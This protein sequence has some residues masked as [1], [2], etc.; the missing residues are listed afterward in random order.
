MH[1]LR[2]KVCLFFGFLFKFMVHELRFRVDGLR[3]YV[4]IFM[5]FGDH[6]IAHATASPLMVLGL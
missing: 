2:P 5:V 3:V 4:V 6:V 1:A